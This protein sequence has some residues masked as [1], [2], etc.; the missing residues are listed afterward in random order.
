MTGSGRAGE[1]QTIEMTTTMAERAA[2]ELDERLRHV[3]ALARSVEELPA[4]W[5]GSDDDRDRLLRAL[6]TPDERLNALVFATLDL[7]THGSSNYDGGARPSPAG[8]AYAREAMTTGAVS[9][10]SEPLLALS[11]RDPVLAGRRSGAG[12]ACAGS[13]RAGGDWPQDPAPCERVDWRPA[14]SWS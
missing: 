8:R 12:R 4:F 9:V 14:A 5:D 11:N 6:A 10:T 7:E 2:D 3:V 1:A 13:A